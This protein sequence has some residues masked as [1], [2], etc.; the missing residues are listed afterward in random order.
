MIPDFTDRNSNYTESEP[1]IFTVKEMAQDDRPRERALK[2]GIG[3]LSNADLLALILRT[4]TTGH[5]I[6]SL[7]RDIMTLCD[8]K[9][10]NLERKSR[11]ELM[12][13]DGI[14][15]MKAQQVEA[16]MEIVRRYSSE[17]IGDRVA[18]TQPDI[19]Y[20]L[21][22]PKIGN[23][24]HEEMWVIFLNR[25][26]RVLGM[27]KVSEG[28][29]TSTIFDVKRILRSVI[30]AQAEGVILCHNH[31][32]GNLHPSGPDDNITRKFQDA[33]KVM[34]IRFLDHMI[35]TTDGFYSYSNS[36]SILS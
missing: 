5:P 16:V 36:S 23:L 29:G 12:Q 32:S 28:G 34:E 20:N 4:G 13:L 35:I 1:Q 7:C 26:N 27:M 6:T 9:F 17:T 19:V 31:P 2:Y 8:Q 11:Q 18:V 25:A 15:E 3:S 24:A 14:G 10:L 30:L 21:M 33:C 22:K